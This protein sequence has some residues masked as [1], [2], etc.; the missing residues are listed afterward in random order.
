MTGLSLPNCSNT[1]RNENPVPYSQS[2]RVR[3]VM[4]I[5]T[6]PRPMPN[7]LGR[8]LLGRVDVRRRS[9]A[10]IVMLCPHRPAA[11]FSIVSSAVRLRP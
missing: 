5:T 7:V 9:A 10:T 1:E 3:N 4:T 8:G 11:S 2:H 6:T